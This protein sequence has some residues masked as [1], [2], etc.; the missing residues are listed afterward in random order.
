M[1]RLQGPKSSTENSN[2]HLTDRYGI[3]GVFGSSGVMFNRVQ[4]RFHILA[5]ATLF[6]D[7]IVS[8]QT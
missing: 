4:A 2:V 8:L 3:Y 7:V 5:V 6:D 1:K